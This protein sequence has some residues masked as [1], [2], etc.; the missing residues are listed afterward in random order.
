MFDWPLMTINCLLLSFMTFL[1]ISVGLSPVSSKGISLWLTVGPIGRKI[2]IHWRFV[3]RSDGF[4]DWIG[5]FDKD[6]I[7]TT[8]ETALSVIDGKFDVNGSRVTDIHFPYTHFG[9][10]FVEK[11]LGYYVGYV[12]PEYWKMR[13]V[14]LI[15]RPLGSHNLTRTPL[16]A[17][18][19]NF[20][21]CWS[22]VRLRDFRRLLRQGLNGL[23]NYS[24]IILDV[25]SHFQPH[26][27]N[28]YLLTKIVQTIQVSSSFDA[29]SRQ[30]SQADLLYHVI[31]L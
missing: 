18:R 21:H 5:L 22:K 23:W 6:F 11:C 3:V 14:P 28:Q 7:K 19:R 1:S 20:L 24:E 26:P 2:G 8:K 16:E 25:L 12:Y 29:Y 9:D 10:R 17:Y 13:N 4:D 30:N 27:R 31:I 15:I